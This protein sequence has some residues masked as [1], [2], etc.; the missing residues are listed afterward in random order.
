MKKM[1]SLICLVVAS[2]AVMAETNDAVANS[3]QTV[4]K[5]V[6]VANDKLGTG[7]Q[8]M[9]T[10][11]NGT[12]VYV[13]D[14]YYHATQYMPYFPTAGTIWPRVV[15]VDCTQA[16]GKVQCNGY[17]WLPAMGRG[18]YLFIV[19]R[20]AVAPVKPAVVIKEQKKKKRE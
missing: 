1:L 7:G 5:T 10:V 17:D 4:P 8:P 2:T 6:L 19:P 16:G 18:E 3:F 20:V 11:G 15:T 13:D 12:A 14:G 9:V